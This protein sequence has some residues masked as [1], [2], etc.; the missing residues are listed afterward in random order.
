MG[1]TRFRG[2]EFIEKSEL[3]FIGADQFNVLLNQGWR[4]PGN[5]R[6]LGDWK[7]LHQLTSHLVVLDVSIHRVLSVM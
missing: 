7:T 2:F 1:I 3:R 4:E 6:N 5:C